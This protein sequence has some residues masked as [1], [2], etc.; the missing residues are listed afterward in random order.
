MDDR[1]WTSDYRTISKQAIHRIFSSHSINRNIPRIF[2][3]DSCSG[4]K[5]KV[6]DSREKIENKKEMNSGHM[7]SP[8]GSGPSLSEG[9]DFHVDVEEEWASDEVNSDYKLV[10]IHA[11]NPGFQAKMNN[12]Y[13]SYLTRLFVVALKRSTNHFLFEIIGKIQEAL[14]DKGKQLTK[15]SF[16]NG[17]EYI[18]FVANKELESEMGV[19]NESPQSRLLSP[20][21]SPAGQNV[22]VEMSETV[23]DGIIAG[24]GDVDYPQNHILSPDID[25]CIDEFKDANF[26]EE[27]AVEEK[28]QREGD[29]NV[30][31]NVA[32]FEAFGMLQGNSSL[33]HDSRFQ[34]LV[35]EHVKRR[36]Q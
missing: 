16:N 15:S 1:I 18:K 29:N 14:H 5:A 10:E 27:H 28:E 9:V 17:T 2:L 26:H 13:G 32:R 4:T 24:N 12:E 6:V 22:M 8:K 19:E 7:T 36:G 34:K 20:N 33:V 35:K 11:S 23:A 3:F 31:S 21:Q 25:E 30:K